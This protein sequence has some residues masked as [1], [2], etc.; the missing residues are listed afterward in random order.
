MAD[1]HLYRYKA[2]VINIVDGDT[3]DVCVDLGFHTKMDIRLRLARVNT[4]EVRGPERE[5]GIDAKKFVCSLIECGDVW[6]Q[7]FK[8]PT[9]K[10]GR[11]IAEVWF[12]AGVIEQYFEECDSEKI[13]RQ[14]MESVYDRSADLEYCN[15]SDILTLAGYNKLSPKS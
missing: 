12:D 6:I 8:D 13:E 9:D 5:D 1:K 10:Y 15:L 14:V 7:T 2:E 4:P 11:W 3:I